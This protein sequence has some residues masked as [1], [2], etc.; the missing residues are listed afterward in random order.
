[1]ILSLSLK[2]PAHISKN[3]NIDSNDHNQ[4]LPY[5]NTVANHSLASI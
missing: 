5:F 2:N 1:M 3:R 4:F